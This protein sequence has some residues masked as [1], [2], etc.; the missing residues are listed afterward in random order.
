MEF[1]REM[2]LIVSVPS[3]DVHLSSLLGSVDA[4]QSVSEAQT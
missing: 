3:L 2:A 1:L 4:A